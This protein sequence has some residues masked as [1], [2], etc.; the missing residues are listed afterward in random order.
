MKTVMSLSLIALL[1]LILNDTAWAQE[2][3]ESKSENFSQI[4]TIE[5]PTIKCGSCVKTVSDAVKKLNGVNEV[6]VDKKSK[7]A[8]VHYDGTKIKQSDIELAISKA[9]YDANEVKRD[10]KAYDSLDDCCK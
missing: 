10:T 6:K 4:V 3:N 5:V 9:G 8:T 1:A 7:T 2:T